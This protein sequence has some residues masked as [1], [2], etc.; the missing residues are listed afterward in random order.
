[1]KAQN[2]FGKSNYKLTDEQWKKLYSAFAKISLWDGVD[3]KKVK[4]ARKEGYSVLNGIKSKFTDFSEVLTDYYEKVIKKGLDYKT[5]NFVVD[6]IWKTGAVVLDKAGYDLS[7]DLLKLAA[8][9]S[10][11]KYVAKE[12][13]YASNLLKMIRG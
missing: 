5:M 2:L 1:M 11:N 9:G 7:S 13:S 8:S 6:S 3:D 12:G 4:E 10:G